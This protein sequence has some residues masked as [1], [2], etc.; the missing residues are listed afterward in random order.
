MPVGLIQVK[1]NGE[2]YSI[3]GPCRSNIP[4]DERKC[5]LEDDI[6]G[7]VSWRLMN[8]RMRIPVRKGGKTLF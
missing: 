2:E 8:V 3:E 1:A 7:R 5:T 4:E 6:S